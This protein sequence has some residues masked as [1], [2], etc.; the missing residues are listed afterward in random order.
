MGLWSGVKA[1]LGIGAAGGVIAGLYADWKDDGKINLSAILDLLGDTA[2]GVGAA[3]GEGWEAFSY[4]VGMMS[5]NDEEAYVLNQDPDYQKLV[6]AMRNVITT[7]QGTESAWGS[8][9]ESSWSTLMSSRLLIPADVTDS[10]LAAMSS[11]MGGCDR[12]IS[13]YD[14]FF[15]S[16]GVFKKACADISE[17]IFSNKPRYAAEQ[18]VTRVVASESAGGLLPAAKHMSE[19]GRALASEARSVA[20]AFS[21]DAILSK[22]D[23]IL[24]DFASDVDGAVASYAAIESAVSTA[25]QRR[26][27]FL[28]DVESDLKK[29]DSV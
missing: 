22:Y 13:L 2:K 23:H 5:S 9:A 26:D 8:C 3:A 16:Y 29:I 4:T 28:Y 11:V 6:V 21:S 10:Q 15:D 24:T 12:L 17:D 1:L 7:C 27:E 14:E 18:F 19:S 20:S 25:E